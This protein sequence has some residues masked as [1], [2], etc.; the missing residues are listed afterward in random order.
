M[1]VIRSPPDT[2]PDLLIAKI[3]CKVIGKWS[4]YFETAME[5][6][7]HSK[8]AGHFPLASDISHLIKQ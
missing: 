8:A 6:F 5:Y 3:K 7:W 4:P 2:D 1:K